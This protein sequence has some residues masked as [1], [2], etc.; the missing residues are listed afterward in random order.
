M[1][2]VAL[3]SR[4]TAKGEGELMPCRFGQGIEKPMEYRWRVRCEDDDLADD[5]ITII[6]DGRVQFT[7]RCDEDGLDQAHDYIMADCGFTDFQARKGTEEY[8]DIFG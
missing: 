5:G 2:W 4:W 3:Q 8:K 1:A 7:G 6:P